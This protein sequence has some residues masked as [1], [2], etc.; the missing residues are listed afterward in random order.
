[1]EK[2]AE[3]AAAGAADG[4]VGMSD[5]PEVLLVETPAD[6][7]PVAVEKVGERSM[8]AP[9]CAEMVEAVGDAKFTGG[10]GG[11]AG[12]VAVGVGAP[13]R[14]PA[15]SVAAGGS[16]YWGEVGLRRFWQ[17]CSVGITQMHT[18]SRAAVLVQ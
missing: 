5:G 12:I 7:P 11:D 18:T 13:L 16:Q 2:E 1:V 14:L 4:V 9:F 17:L 3:G 6:V 8:F 15:V 10:E